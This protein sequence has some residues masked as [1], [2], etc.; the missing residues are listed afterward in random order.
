M[1]YHLKTEQQS[2]KCTLV[3]RRKKGET[4]FI[5]CVA[6][7]VRHADHVTLEVMSSLH[8]SA[9]PHSRDC[10]PA[11]NTVSASQRLNSVPPGSKSRDLTLLT[12]HCRLCLCG[13][14][15]QTA[16]ISLDASRLQISG[17]SDCWEKGFNTSV[18]KGPH[19]SS[20]WTPL[21]D[22]VIFTPQRQWVKKNCCIQGR[23]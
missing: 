17:L 5:T 3:V 2:I 18:N 6:P 9:A 16:H 13:F 19:C 23:D 21:W 12:N 7:A 1:K 15:W 11:S 10:P 20:V 22:Y 4:V 14:A 8:H